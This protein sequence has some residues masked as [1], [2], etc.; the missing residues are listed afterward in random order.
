MGV[1]YVPGSVLVSGLQEDEIDKDL[2]LKEL[3][4]KWREMVTI[5]TNDFT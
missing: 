3:L 5:Y 1:F 4:V 2:I